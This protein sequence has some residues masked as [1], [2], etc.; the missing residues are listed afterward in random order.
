MEPLY[1]SPIP[2]DAVEVIMERYENGSKQRAAYF[3]DG[4][5]IGFRFWDESGALA[6]EFGLKD[7]LKHGLYRV[8]DSEDELSEVATYVEGKEHGE[9]IQ[10]CNGERI[11]SYV[12]DH[13]T[14][15]DLWFCSPGILSEER[16]YLDGE[17]HGFERWWNCDN[18]TVNEESHFW[19]GI[20]HGIFRQWNPQHKL[21]RGYPQ[22]F[23]HGQRVTK[24]QYLRAC[25]TDPTL[26]PFVAEDNNPTR[27]LPRRVALS[28]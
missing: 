13:G 28:S 16:H 9:T 22:Y 1:T 14:G 27:R 6:I 15:V 10:Y 2:D 18:Q 23:I 7:G 24:R 5:E 12:M 26:P 4:K 3:V 11:G 17:R 20:Q 8:L 21:R 19:K 25:V